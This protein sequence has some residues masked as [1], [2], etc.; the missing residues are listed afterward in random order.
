MITYTF[1]LSGLDWAELKSVLQTDHF[2]NGRSPEQYK[3]SFE[4]SFAACIASDGERI[5]GNVRVLSDGICNAYIVDV[6][7]DSAYRH[8]GIAT[9]MMKLCLEKLPGQHVHLFTDDAMDFY[10]RLGFEAHDTGMALVV[11]QWLVNR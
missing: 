8:R 2:D 7:T 5:V 10:K 9:Q 4:N 1:D 11:G 6:W 3:A